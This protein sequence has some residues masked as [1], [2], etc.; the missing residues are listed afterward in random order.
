MY[1]IHNS[2]L[3]VTSFLSPSANRSVPDF[4]KL[5]IR[6][7]YYFLFILVK[8]VLITYLIDVSI[9]LVVFSGK[10]WN[11]WLL[12]SPKSLDVS[13]VL[14][15]MAYQWLTWPTRKLGW[16]DTC[17]KNCCDGLTRRWQGARCCCLLT[18]LYQ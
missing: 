4:R 8:H 11:L 6:M 2:E 18:M 17:M 5:N 16:M 9:I 13:K 1:I 14:L 3:T 10:K 7:L 12:E 15:L